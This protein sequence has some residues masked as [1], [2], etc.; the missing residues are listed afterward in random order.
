MEAGAEAHTASVRQAEAQIQLAQARTQ[1]AHA[2]AAFNNARRA[3]EKA[4]V[5]GI[6][7]KIAD[8]L[9]D[10][11]AE[12]D[13]ATAAVTAVTRSV[14]SARTEAP[15]SSMAVSPPP[16]T[17]TSEP[18]KK[19]PSQVAQADTPLPE[20]ASSEGRPRYLAVA[21]V[22]MISA[23]QVY[24]PASP[25]R[26]MGFSARWVV[27]MWSKIISVLKRAACLSK[28]AINSGPWTPS[29]SAGQ[30]STSVV[31]ISWPPWAMPVMSTGFRLARAA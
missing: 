31:V 4:D 12:L 23:S 5:Q 30:L 25:T 13:S 17:A 16:T 22:A 26:R 7:R 8:A 21:P 15:A 11:K 6:V 1:E 3:K 29:G 2:S 20:K 10:A 14:A 18:R 27:W 28:R 9:A 19:K 24:S